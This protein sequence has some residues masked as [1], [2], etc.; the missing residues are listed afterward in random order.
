M[1]KNSVEKLKIKFT[2]MAR[3]GIDWL[4][5]RG[6]IDEREYKEYYHLLVDSIDKMDDEEFI[7]YIES[8]ESLHLETESK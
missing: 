2:A 1:E 7:R 6:A 4:K 8:L 5:V 3:E